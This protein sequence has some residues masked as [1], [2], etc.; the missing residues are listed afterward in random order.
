MAGMAGMFDIAVSY[1]HLANDPAPAGYI[2]ARGWPMGYPGSSFVVV[3][4]H[5][6]G[7]AV[8]AHM[9]VIPVQIVA[10][11]GR[12]AV[13]PGHMVLAD[14]TAVVTAHTVEAPAARTAA[15]VDK[16]SQVVAGM[17]IPDPSVV[18]SMLPV[19]S[20]LIDASPLIPLK[21]YHYTRV[22]KQSS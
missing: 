12:T 3:P 7:T 22:E 15:L 6:A 14:H 5:I 21:V 1:I 10:E 8:V 13:R 17:H 16:R 2:P 20:L 19:H 18:C 9:V 11:P 4:V